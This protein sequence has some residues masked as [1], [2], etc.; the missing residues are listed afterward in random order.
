MTWLTVTLSPGLTR[1]V[2]MSASV[3]PS[4]TSGS[5]N[6]FTSAMPGLSERERAVDGIE[7]PVQVGQVVLLDPRGR[8]GDG[9]PA[10]PNDWRLQLIEALLGD[11]RGDLRAEPAGDRGLVYDHAPAGT[12]HRGDD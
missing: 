7:H 3:S 12:P 1:Q 5:R 11:P 8:I 9:V 6:C 10:D 2:T 4:P